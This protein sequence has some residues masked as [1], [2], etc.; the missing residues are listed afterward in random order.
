MR[1]WHAASWALQ[2]GIALGQPMLGWLARAPVLNHPLLLSTSTRDVDV[3]AGLIGLESP[4]ERAHP[5]PARWLPASLA[6]GNYHRARAQAKPAQKYSKNLFQ[7]ADPLPKTH[8]NT[9]TTIG[10]RFKE[11]RRSYATLTGLPLT[12]FKEKLGVL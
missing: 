11:S 3:S 4:R 6:P 7:K 12:H 9:K 1:L 2:L 5:S 10:W 8:K